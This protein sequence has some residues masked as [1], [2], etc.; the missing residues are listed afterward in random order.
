MNEKEEL[1]TVHT[2]HDRGYKRS[3]SQP[4]EFLHFLKKYVKA[5]WMLELEESQLSL[6][7]KEFVDKDYEGREADL[8]Y[9]VKRT[10]GEEIFVFILQ[11]LQSTVDYT[12]IFRILIYVVNNLL[13]YFLNTVKVKRE[14]KDFRLPAMVPIVFYNGESGWTAVRNLRDYQTGGEL[15][16]D[17]VLNLEYYL[18]N[19]SDIEEQDILS[20]NTVLDNIMYCDKF[21]RKYELAEAIRTAYD[22]IQLLGNQEKEEF[23]NWVKTI[24]LSVCGNREAVVEEI[25]SWAGNGV[26]DMAFKYN[27]IKAFEDERAE[28][29]AEGMVEGKAESIIEILEESGIVPEKLRKLIKEQ[30]NLETLGN[31]LKKAAHVNSVEEFQRYIV[32]EME[33]TE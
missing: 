26:D 21:R 19:L 13:R 5:D 22:R 30:R 8:I 31:W 10:T 29:K 16:G 6:C 33:K 7:D 23:N 14:G 28:G 27:I 12:M 3:L 9:R 15:F 1:R 4:R 20:T 17:H 32:Q 25:L 18:V 24:L 11:E 2:P